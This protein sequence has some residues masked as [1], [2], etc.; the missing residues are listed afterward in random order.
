MGNAAT[1]LLVL[2]SGGSPKTYLD[3]GLEASIQVERPRVALADVPTIEVLNDVDTSVTPVQD[4][5]GVESAL[6]DR[7]VQHTSPDREVAA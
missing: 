3:D 1:D 2:D 7:F 5:T 6:V 4:V